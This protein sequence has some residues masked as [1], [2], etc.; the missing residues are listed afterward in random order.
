MNNTYNVTY[1]GWIKSCNAGDFIS[2]VN[3]T[4]SFCGT[5]SVTGGSYNA[6]YE[7]WTNS[8]LIGQAA[9]GNTSAVSWVQN[10]G[11]PNS[12]YN[13]TYDS[14]MSGS[15]N[16]STDVVNAINGTTT[17]RFSISVLFSNNSNYV[18]NKT[19][20]NLNTNSST[21]WSGR[22][23][24]TNCS[25]GQFYNAVNSAFL[26]GTP[27]TYNASYMTST[28]NATYDAKPSNTYNST[29]DSKM[30]GAGNTTTQIQAVQVLS[31]QVINTT[32]RVNATGVFTPYVCLNMACTS[33]ITK[34][35]TGTTIYG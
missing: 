18:N 1:N 25:A 2:T 27:S 29:Y 17:S 28:Y 12:T 30:G 7:Y 14:K 15:G 16:T 3:S 19:E 26:C 22:A 13:A 33:N 8:T 31:T 34:N 32:L 23:W 35:A 4:G 11:Y 20:A 5:P 24:P 21:Y 6:S 9:T 10:R